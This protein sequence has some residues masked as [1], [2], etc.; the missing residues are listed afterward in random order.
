M[1]L[2][3]AQ[4]QRPPTERRPWGLEWRSSVWFITLVVGIAITTDLLIYSIIVPVI[5]FRLQNL[6]YDG[7]S[8]LVGWL[9][10]A[11]SAALVI[12][13]PPIAF[14]SEKYKNRKI[15]LLLGQAALIGSQVMLMEAPTFWVMALARVAQGI[16]ACVIWVVGLALICDTVPEKIV[17]K[18]L[19]LAMMGMSLGFLIGP[20]VAGALDKRFGFR[21][22]FIFGII[23]TAIEL[24][25]RLLIIERKEA[26][27]WDASFTNL[28]GRNDPSKERVAY[29]AVQGE[30]RPEET[31]TP[32][33]VPSH[34]QARAETERQPKD[35]PAEPA[36]LS[37]PR[38]L[39]K[40][41]RSP[42]AL[43]AVFL[44]LSYGIMI[45]SL[46]PVLPLYLQSTY[47]FDV[48]K[49]GLIYIAAV[50]P[51]FISS[52]L[53][54]WYADR[55]GTIVSTV[56]CLVGS[57][58]FWCLLV[59][60]SHLA[61]FIT[62]F[63]LLNLFA[64]GSISP[65][66]AEF[67]M[68]TRSLEGVGCETL[69]DGHVYGAFNVAYGLGSAIGPVIGGQLYDHV[70]PNRGW[71]EL[72][73]FNAALVVVSTL[74]TLCWFGETAVIKRAVQYF[75]RRTSAKSEVDEGTA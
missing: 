26:I 27:R 47:G 55:G 25:G 3:T 13:T 10:F 35:E 8:G 22:P 7:V 5:P 64:T 39:F 1:S 56:V 65:I 75:R 21:G 57:L 15:P 38:L 74:V 9:L 11:Y 41:V 43:S 51:S 66:T 33:R 60:R 16:S 68:V 42:R 34:T 6:G 48:S 59:I 28:V 69:T 49:V 30:K 18:Q 70:T 50:V 37:I 58:P 24:I 45:S 73:L 61:Y 62:M 12:F 20:P 2:S 71:L 14:L 54:G 52:P 36:Q 17:G 67:A 72:C 40:L 44:T 4:V 63:A 29:G 53:S 32:T 19:G 31:E 46:E 23:V